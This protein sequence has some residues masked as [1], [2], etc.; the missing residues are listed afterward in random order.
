MAPGDVL[1]GQDRHIARLPVVPVLIAT[2]VGAVAYAGGLWLDV[3]PPPG[4]AVVPLTLAPAAAVVAALLLAMRARSEADPSLWWPVVGLL[5]ASVAM[6]LQLIAFP[7]VS[8]GGGV[9]GA[10]PQGSLLYPM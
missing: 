4:F 2:L 1:D 3:L 6:T 10:V 8:P 9:F 5:V 7:A